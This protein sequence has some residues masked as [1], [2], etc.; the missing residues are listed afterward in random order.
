MQYI[1]TLL[2]FGKGISQPENLGNGRLREAIMGVGEDKK[3]VSELRLHNMHLAFVS[4][5]C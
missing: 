3:Y 2:A 1:F 4:I 5:V